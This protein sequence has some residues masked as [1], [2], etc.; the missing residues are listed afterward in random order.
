M[1]SREPLATNKLVSSE[2][3]VEGTEDKQVLQYLFEGVAMKVNLV[4]PGAPPRSQP[5]RLAKAR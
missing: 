2:D 3:K 5:A 1:N 4:Y